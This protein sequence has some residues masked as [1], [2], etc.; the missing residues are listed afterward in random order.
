MKSYRSVA[1]QFAE[2]AISGKRIVGAEIVAR[3]ERFQRDLKRDDL[4]FRT[5]DADFVINIIQTTLVHKQGESL[6]GESLMGK[7][8]LLQD[9]Q[10][11]VVYNLLGF[12]YK[13]T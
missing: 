6:D 10:V 4:E 9:W 1:I 8:F 12:F 3:C 13:G 7:P 11:F 5:H 2:D